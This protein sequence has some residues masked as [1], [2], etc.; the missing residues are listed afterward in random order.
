MINFLQYSSRIGIVQLNNI[1]KK[2]ALNF[3]ML[4]E[5]NFY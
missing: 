1:N 2:N 5:L 4:K 3:Q